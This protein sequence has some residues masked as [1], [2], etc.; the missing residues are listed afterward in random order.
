MLRGEFAL[1]VVPVHLRRRAPWFPWGRNGPVPSAC[2]RRLATASALKT[3][4]PAGPGG[5]CAFLPSRPRLWVRGGVPPR[6]LGPIGPR[7]GPRRL[8]REGLHI[9][10]PRARPSQANGPCSFPNVVAS[11][12][13][14]RL[15]DSWRLAQAHHALEGNI[16]CPEPKTLTSDSPRALEGGSGRGFSTGRCR[17]RE[18]KKQGQTRRN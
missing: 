6:A 15:Y 4:G 12:E 3:T 14:H 1:T 11:G 5:A 10:L 17:L 2:K 9:R 16:L 18:S 8:S 13:R 7:W